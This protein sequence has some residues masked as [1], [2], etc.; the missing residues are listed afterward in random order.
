MKEYKLGE[1]TIL[2]VEVPEGRKPRIF[3][4][5]NKQIECYE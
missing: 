2:V 3:N 1:N 4:P 5:N